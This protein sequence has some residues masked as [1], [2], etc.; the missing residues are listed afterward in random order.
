MT[1]LE[2][3]SKLHQ[4]VDYVEDKP[5]A[6]KLLEIVKEFLIAD[7]LSEPEEDDWD[8]QLTPEQEAQ[9][10]KAIEDSNDEKN[11]VSEEDFK[12]YFA[13]YLRP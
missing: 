10:R 13:R 3:K 12:Q 11:C 6:E 7:L 5:T 8:E 1:L 9:L 2:I 4:M